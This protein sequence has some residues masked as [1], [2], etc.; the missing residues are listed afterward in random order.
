MLSANVT[1][2]TPK[3]INH[4]D[5]WS[6]LLLWRTFRA[7]PYANWIVQPCSVFGNPFVSRSARFVKDRP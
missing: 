4:I 7:A 2:V 1:E 3:T 5:T 6:A